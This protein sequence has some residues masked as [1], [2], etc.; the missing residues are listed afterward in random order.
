MLKHDYKLSLENMLYLHNKILSQRVSAL[1]DSVQ[2]LMIEAE[3]D[4]GFV[5]FYSTLFSI[6]YKKR[7]ERNN[8]VD[9]Y[10]VLFLE[11][12]LKNLHFRL[13]PSI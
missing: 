8:I 13:Y 10:C 12:S 5:G 6:A 7:K 2:F 11:C 9:Y 3:N 4:V 1:N